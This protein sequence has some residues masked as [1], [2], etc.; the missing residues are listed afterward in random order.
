MIMY[1]C[2]LEMLKKMDGVG[3]KLAQY[4]VAQKG[5]FN[6]HKPCVLYREDHLFTNAWLISDFLI[7]TKPVPLQMNIQH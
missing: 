3:P 5:F 2:E 6:Q 1:Q 7:K 4:C